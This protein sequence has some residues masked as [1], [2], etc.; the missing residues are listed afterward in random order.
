MSGGNVSNLT[1]ITILSSKLNIPN[2]AFTTGVGSSFIVSRVLTPQV[3]SS[4]KASYLC[5]TTNP[6]GLGDIF[7]VDTSTSTSTL[8]SAGSSYTAVGTC[9]YLSSGAAP[10]SNYN[11]GI[12]VVANKES[13]SAKT[14]II[15]NS[16]GD[17]ITVSSEPTCYKI[18]VSS[19]YSVLKS[20]SD[21]PQE[22]QSYIYGFQAAAEKLFHVGD[23]QCVTDKNNQALSDSYTTGVMMLGGLLVAGSATFSAKIYVLYDDNSVAISSY[24][25][26]FSS[27]GNTYYIACPM[28]ISADGKNIVA[29]RPYI[30]KSY[31]GAP[32]ILS[33]SN[34]VVTGLPADDAFIIPENSGTKKIEAVG[35]VYDSGSVNSSQYYPQGSVTNGTYLILEPKT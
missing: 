33:S 34:R 32:T 24:N 17:G 2:S 10:Y 9:R 12:R 35:V 23:L 5:Q 7:T 11:L 31:A 27:S 4:T 28:K 14:S 22:D 19:N 26:T 25:I 15:R 1:Y 16:H 6:Y 3:I 29:H 21:N 18:A 8:K 30:T 13:L 20:G